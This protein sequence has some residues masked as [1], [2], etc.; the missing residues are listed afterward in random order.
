MLC[1]RWCHIHLFTIYRCICCLQYIGCI[2]CI[3]DPSLFSF[4]VIQRL[5]FYQCFDAFSQVLRN[6]NTHAQS[7]TQC[8]G[9]HVIDLTCVDDSCIVKPVCGLKFKCYSSAA[10]VC[11]NRNE[12]REICVSAIFLTRPR[13]PLTGRHRQK[14]RFQA[15]LML[16]KQQQEQLQ[17]LQ[18]T[19]RKASQSGFSLKS[20]SLTHLVDS[21]RQQ[22]EVTVFQFM[23]FID[24]KYLQGHRICL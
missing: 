2:P 1:L 5:K 21:G 4:R 13:T 3:I 20:R 10:R 16:L 19:P 9:F 14:L 17:E 12:R 11:N 24:K 18:R 22:M 7:H 8:K 15:K 6:L 23:T